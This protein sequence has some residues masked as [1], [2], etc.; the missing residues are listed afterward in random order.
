MSDN[1]TD[2]DRSKYEIFLRPTKKRVKRPATDHDRALIGAGQTAL[3]D[4]RDQLTE[5]KTRFNRAIRTKIDALDAEERDLRALSKEKKREEL[6]EAHVYIDARQGG[7]ILV[8][9]AETGETLMGPTPLSSA[10]REVFHATKTQTGLFDAK[11]PVKTNEE[12]ARKLNLSEYLADDPPASVEERVALAL[13]ACDLP[14]ELKDQ[15][16]AF[17][18][19]VEAEDDDE[20]SPKAKKP[21]AKKEPKETKKRGRPKKN[22]DP[23]PTPAPASASTTTDEQPGPAVAEKDDALPKG[24]P[25]AKK[26]LSDKPAEGEML[27]L[28]TEEEHTLEGSHASLVSSLASRV[29]DKAEDEGDESEEDEAPAPEPVDDGDVAAIPEPTEEVIEDEVPVDVYVDSE[30]PDFSNSEGEPVIEPEEE[31]V[32]ADEAPA[33]VESDDEIP[34][35]GTEPEDEPAPA[36]EPTETLAVEPE[37]AP[38][39]EAPADVPAPASPEPEAPPPAPA[40]EPAPTVATEKRDKKKRDTAPT[41]P[42][43]AEP[44][45]NEG[46]HWGLTELLMNQLTQAVTATVRRIVFFSP[47]VLPQIETETKAPIKPENMRRAMPV[48]F[49][50]LAAKGNYTAR[51]LS[52]GDVAYYLLVKTPR[53]KDLTA[54][55]VEAVI[56]AYLKGERDPKILRTV[57][58]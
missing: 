27:P 2:D 6:R 41:P 16:T 21:K 15:I 24:P 57:S 26:P 46:N 40:L 36:V 1:H 23:A 39:V 10:Q 48:V 47:I 17:F 53:A 43:V 42:A 20:P 50:D 56:A 29:A 45:L 30:E 22:S 5:L 7:V 32:V 38:A 44:E 34:D 31:P 11:D 25:K 37:P 13:D 33:D 51:P 9:D 8:R 52:N 54:D 58:A 3:L 12:L 28:A 55:R 35:Y 18:E 19:E 14:D 4:K 49:R